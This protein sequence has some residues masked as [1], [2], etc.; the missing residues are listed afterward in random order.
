MADQF[1]EATY[2]A[3][4]SDLHLTEEEPVHPKYPLWKKY[5]TRQFFFDEDLCEFLLHIEQQAH[6]QPVELILNGDIFDFDSVTA[7]PESPV[8][9]VS[10]WE[11]KRGLEPREEKSRFKIQK[12]LNDH[13]EFV[14]AMSEFIRRGNRVVFVIGNHDLELHFPAVQHEIRTQLNLTSYEQERL[15]FVEWFF[16]SNQDTLIE[17]GNQYDPYC[18]CEDPMNPFVKGYNHI[19][20]KLPFGN[21]ACR[22][23]MNGLGFFNP[24]TEGAYIMTLKDYISIFLR[25]MVRAQPLL[26]FTWFGGSVATLARTIRD[27][28][29]YPTKNAFT[30]E[31]R[32]AKMAEKANAEPR[33]IREMKELIVPSASSNPF[34][35]ARELWL[36][37][38]FIILLSTVMIFYIFTFLKAA[39]GISLFWAFIPLFLFLP[40][41]L[42]YSRSV[43]SMVSSYKEPDDRILA[44]TALI[45]K[46]KRVV[47]GHTHLPRH[48]IIGAV[49]HLNSGTWSPAFKDVEHKTPIEQRNYV[50]ISPAEG[51]RKA[52]LLKFKRNLK[53]QRDD[54]AS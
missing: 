23:I 8:F 38:A 3:I 42:F 52:E 2:T 28:M 13:R 20:L 45:T 39:F 22:Y 6:G 24:H 49:E 46:V 47:Y 31:T 5:K 40:F 36:D 12:I 1:K 11:Q 54:E 17:H 10:W 18:L 37:R 41:F 44:I 33:M 32:I 9:R 48:E 25:Y 16:I 30:I 35:I 4:I 43:I 50:W 53:P 21:I 34:L 7:I 27:R 51:G 15:R 14:T 26:V 19:Y 29:A